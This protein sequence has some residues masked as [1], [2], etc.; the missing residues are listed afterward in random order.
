MF[1]FLEGE[2]ARKTPTEAV[3]DVH[4]AG[5]LLSI[6]LQCYTALPERGRLRLLVHVHANESGIRLFGFL[7]ERERVLFRLLQTVSGVGPAVAL[8]L[9][10]SEPP[11]AIAARIRA[12][13]V[14]GLTRTKGIGTKTA[15]RLVLELK[16]K[17]EVE[18]GA[19]VAGETE[20]LL[21]QAL[22]SLG[23]DAAE[24]RTRAQAARKA[25]PADAPVEALLR[26]AL[27]ARAAAR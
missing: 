4:G 17:V 18:P 21:L 26:H 1:D 13:D 23:L 25:L 8:T 15:E 16:D 22:E 6:S 9:L 10:S 14:K 3:L 2:L 27:Q 20:R 11:P 19:A 7:D 24:A 12:G 5:Y